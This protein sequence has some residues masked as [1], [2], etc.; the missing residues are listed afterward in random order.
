[1]GCEHGVKRA[2]LRASTVAN[3]PMRS[4]TRIARFSSSGWLVEK[5]EATRQIAAIPK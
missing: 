3:R 5:P 4:L 1:M 2:D